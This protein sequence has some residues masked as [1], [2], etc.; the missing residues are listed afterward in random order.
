MRIGR[1][2]LVKKRDELVA[3]AKMAK[4]Q[5]QVQTT[6]KNASGDGPHQRTEPLRR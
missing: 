5:T 3:R 2:E 1:D 6:L 4:A